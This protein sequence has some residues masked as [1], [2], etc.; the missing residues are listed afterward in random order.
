MQIGQRARVLIEAFG[1]GSAEPIGDDRAMLLRFNDTTRKGTTRSC[2]V[3]MNLNAL[4]NQQEKVWE[5]I[6]AEQVIG[7]CQTAVVILT[8]IPQDEMLVIME[9]LFKHLLPGGKVGR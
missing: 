7:D 1:L 2:Q 5:G 6:P 8:N 9:Q 4:D 3:R